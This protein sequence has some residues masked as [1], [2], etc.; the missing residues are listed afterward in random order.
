MTTAPESDE[1][2]HSDSGHDQ[3]QSLK[4]PAEDLDQF[5]DALSRNVRL[6][7]SQ[8]DELKQF[9]LLSEAQ[10]QVWLA[11]QLIKVVDVLNTLE[12]PDTI[13]QI[14]TT[15]ERRIELYTYLVLVSPTTSVYVMNAGG[16]L[17]LILDHME[18]VPSW[19]LTPEVK[20][21]KAKFDVVCSR[22]RNRLTHRRNEM[23]T[24]I[25]DSLDTPWTDIVALCHQI[26]AMGDRV[27]VTLKVS[28]QMVAWVAFLRAVYRDHMGPDKKVD[29]YWRLVDTQLKEVRDTTNGDTKKLSRFFA[30]VLTHDREA[31][32]NPSIDDL[33]L[34]SPGA[35]DDPPQRR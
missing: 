2:T 10:Q 15:M 28:L 7:T 17:S 35:F 9:V 5:A 23:K 3:T 24:M 16:P 14:P 33:E 1:L 12:A 21:D 34:T 22:I 13:Y 19:G 29:K 25:R 32:G 31:Y 18:T 8:K 4:R 27:V 6:K 26:L 30:K 11:A 20:A